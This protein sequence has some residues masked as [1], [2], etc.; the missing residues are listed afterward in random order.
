MSEMMEWVERAAA[1]NF[2]ACEK[3]QEIIAREASTTFGWLVAGAAAALSFAVR[4]QAPSG[5]QVILVVLALWLAACAG[6]LTWRAMMFGAFPSPTN[7][8][9][10]LYQPNYALLSLREAELEN[11]QQAWNYC[12]VDS[13]TLSSAV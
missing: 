12:N 7:E 6:V 5:P 13:L 4:P 8:P 3:T 9:R 1:A 11:L 10:N 2:A